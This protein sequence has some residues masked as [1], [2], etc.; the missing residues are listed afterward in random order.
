MLIWFCMNW[1]IDGCPRNAFVQNHFIY[2][3]TE[4][5]IWYACI[6]RLIYIQQHQLITKICSQ[7]FN[8]WLSIYNFYASVMC[9]FFNECILLLQFENKSFLTRQKKIHVF[10]KFLFKNCLRYGGCWHV[11]FK[12]L[13]SVLSW[14]SCLW[15]KR[16]WERLGSPDF[17][18]HDTG[19][20]VTRFTS[21]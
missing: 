12:P 8:G 5:I 17:M 2:I 9:K 20:C 16:D 10:Q 6:Y 14:W 1:Y 18:N 3:T 11:D 4:F 7:E 19:I 13:L 21:L 15:W